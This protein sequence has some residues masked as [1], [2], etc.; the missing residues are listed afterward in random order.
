M[1]DLKELQPLLLE[2]L[3]AGNAAEALALA[4]KAL[5]DGAKPMEFFEVCIGPSLKD[6]GQR[7]ETLDIFLPEMVIAAE[8]VQKVNEQVIN[9]AIEADNSEEI[10][11]AGKVLLATVQG[12]LHDI[13]KNMV[14]MMLQVNGYQ[15]INMGIDVPADTIVAKAEEENVDIIGLSALLTTTL[16]YM[17]DV[18]SFLEGKGIR[19]KYKVIVGG[20]APTPEYTQEIGA[21]GHGRNAAAAVELCNQ[22][23]T[24]KA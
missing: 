23:M 7:F 8:V 17:H 4:Q 15:V 16:P 24:I 19:H 11:S 6:I 3:L 5:D 13:G 9:P 1:K 20:A 22:I 21:D 2:Y 10:I 12:D 18:I 14:D